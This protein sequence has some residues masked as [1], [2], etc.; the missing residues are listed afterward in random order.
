[1]TG[2]TTIAAADSV[3]AKANTLPLQNAY[4]PVSD[5]SQDLSGGA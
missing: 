3:E 2:I 5:N 1:M 4:L